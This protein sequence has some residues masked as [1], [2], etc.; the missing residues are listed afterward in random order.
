MYLEGLLV[1][2]RYYIIV[3]HVVGADQLHKQQRWWVQPPTPLGV[4]LAQT[5]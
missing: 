1:P 5:H 2:V 3:F 4:Q